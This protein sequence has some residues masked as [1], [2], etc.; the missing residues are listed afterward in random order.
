MAQ[1]NRNAEPANADPQTGRLGFRYEHEP[2]D[3]RPYVVVYPH[4]QFRDEG[5]RLAWERAVSEIAPWKLWVPNPQYD[6]ESKRPEAASP[7]LMRL[8]LVCSEI[9]ALAT[10]LDGGRTVERMPRA[11]M[12]RVARDRELAK[13]RAQARGLSA[14]IEDYA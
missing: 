12:S 3:F 6:P 11:G 14:G 13:L 10:G 2:P 9:A 8:E 1:R 5:E 4:A 7:V